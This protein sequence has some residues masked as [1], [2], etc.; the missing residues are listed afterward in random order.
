MEPEDLAN[1]ANKPSE[2][3]MGSGGR[4]GGDC[5]LQLQFMSIE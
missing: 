4:V 2:L 5:G 3:R 1:K